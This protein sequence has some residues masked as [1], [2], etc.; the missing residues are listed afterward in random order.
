MA[1]AGTGAQS[2]QERARGARPGSRRWR[3]TPAAR[4]ARY[5]AGSVLRFVL[6]AIPLALLVLAL[7]AVAA[8]GFG[9][10]PD[11]GPLEA[12]GLARP[13]GLPPAVAWAALLFEAVALVALFLLI[14]GR[15]GS[16][17]LD[18]L[19]T[20][21]AA[22]LFRGPLL[23]LTLAALTRLPTEPFWQMA[24]AA[25]VAEPAAAL[26]VAALARAARRDRP[27]EGP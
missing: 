6:L 20:G 23:V 1:G 17:W 10:A 27:P 13:G 8:D 4:G 3:E 5:H 18:G 26:A 9:Y 7:A 16:W 14:E 24:R 12:R 19:A 2:I 21:L 25:L 11:L 22:W 15:S